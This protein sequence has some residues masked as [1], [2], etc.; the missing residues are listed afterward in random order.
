MGKYR[1]D[2]YLFIFINMH[3]MKMKNESKNKQWVESVNDQEIQ[4]ENLTP[5]PET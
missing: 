4:S 1:A 5:M 2:Q 3:S